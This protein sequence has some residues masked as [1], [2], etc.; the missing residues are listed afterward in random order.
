MADTTYAPKVYKDNGGDRLVIAPTGVLQIEGQVSGLAPGNDYFVDSTNGSNSNSGLSWDLAVATLDYA[1]GLCTASAGDRIFIAPW[2]AES[3]T[4]ATEVNCDVAGVEIIG[5]K[6]GKQ[7]PTFTTDAA[8]GSITVAAAN[9]TLRNLKMVA[10]F[11]GGSTSAI[12]IAATGDGCTL[13]GIVCR[14]SA[15]NTEWLVHVSVATTVEEL[16]IT[17]C[18]F[19]G[20][21]GESMT[22]S[23][24]FAGTSTWTTIEDTYIHVDSSDDTVDHLAGA[25]VGFRMA[26]C[27]IVNEDTTT[28]LYCVRQKSDGTGVH[29]DCRFAYNKVDAEISVGA[30]SWWLEN[31]ASNTIAEGTILEPA[32]THAI[33]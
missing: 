5:V 12:T 20:L 18:D 26:R 22:N 4:T 8:A 7:M 16:R 1:I 31:R 30:A 24:L 17:H 13:D 9:V 19:R 27:I 11:A 3:L 14:D 15:A 21:I 6:R 10:G 33:P 23:I 28:A 2:H 25:A 29:H 32:A